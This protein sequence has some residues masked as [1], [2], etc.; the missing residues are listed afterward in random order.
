MAY[1]NFTSKNSFQK[2]T[3]YIYTFW[4]VI[5]FIVIFVSLFPLYYIFLQ[6]EKW[7]P[8]AH[9]LNRIWAKTLFF[10][11]GIRSEIQYNFVP[12][13]KGTYVFV[14]N[15]F[16][17]WDIAVLGTFIDNYFAFVGKSS[18]K[19]I[20][21]IGYMFSKL[22]IQVD[23]S[24]KES[25]A[26]SMT[27]AMRAL[28]KGRSMMMFAEGGILTRNPPQMIKPFK[29]GAFLM[30]IQHQVPI[31]PI[32]LL[33]SYQ[34]I[35]DEDLLMSRLPIRAIVHEPINTMGLK[36]SN[37]DELK[38]QTWNII[39]NELDKFHGVSQMSSFEKI[40]KI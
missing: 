31:V 26:K 34:I 28:E 15:H 22:H 24:E 21:L 23:R 27:R 20:P 35:W 30:A 39:Q 18:V 10:F 33:N 9:Y 17:Y 4:C 14:T 7:K 37:M 8:K 32:T 16:S 29:D 6:K 5:W 13:P 11:I 2:F 38:E 19:K 12:D 36:T 1:S 25:R 40:S 3:A